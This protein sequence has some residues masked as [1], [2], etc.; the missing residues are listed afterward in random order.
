MDD[1]EYESEVDGG[2]AEV[3][4]VAE[5][6]NRGAPAKKKRRG[7][8]AFQWT[9]SRVEVLLFEAA[10]MNVTEQPWGKGT[11]V[12]LKLLDKLRK[13]PLFSV[14]ASKL[15]AQALG[16]KLNKIIEPGKVEELRPE[17]GHATDR[18]RMVDCAKKLY[19]ARGV[20]EQKKK[21]E[22][23]AN[24]WD[25]IVS[26]LA[27][28][29]SV[30]RGSNV[31]CARSSLHTSKRCRGPDEEVHWW[32]L[33]RL[34]CSHHPPCCCMGVRQRDRPCRTSAVR[35]PHRRA[36]ASAGFCSSPPFSCFCRCSSRCIRFSAKLAAATRHSSHLCRG[37]GTV[38]C[39]VAYVPVSLL[40]ANTE[41]GGSG[42]C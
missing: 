27:A 3:A 11:G 22:K 2:S 30:D 10:A 29:W 12:L 15:S 41:R 13:S 40:A 24:S 31:S 34:W 37:K 23:D 6:S 7:A 35:Q 32:E 9:T 17:S 8:E 16:R 4:A 5:E 28:A 18:Q 14:D 20:K 26:R 33:R 25:A 19:A 38:L 42:P 36:S 21:D 39:R 1:Y